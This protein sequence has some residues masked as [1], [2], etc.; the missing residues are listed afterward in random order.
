MCDT[1]RKAAEAYQ[2]LCRRR[3]RFTFSNDKQIEVVFK[4]QN[5]VHLAGLRKLNDINE[6]QDH[7]SAVNIFKMILQ[8]KI[9][10]YDLQQSVHYDTDAEERIFFLIELENLLNTQFAVWD[11]N[12]QKGSRIN[13]RLKSKVIFFRNESRDFYL[14][15]GLAP[16]GQTYYPETFFLRFDDAYIRGQDIVKIVSVEI[17]SI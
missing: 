15:L 16:D 6:F 3:Y 14:M 11:F 4:P 13:T 9:N 8:G 1:L 2:G 12:P 5:F 10:D 7:H 17:C